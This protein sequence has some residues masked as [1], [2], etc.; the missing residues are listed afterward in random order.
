M[1]SESITVPPHP[2]S[3]ESN[4]LTSRNLCAL[5]S[6]DESEV[7]TFL[8]QR[9]VDNS[10]IAGL[11]R[12]NGLISSHNRG[13]F[14]GFR[15]REGKLEGVALVGRKTI[16]ETHNE[17]ALE[18]FAELSLKSTLSFLLRGE[19]NQAERLLSY[20]A[21][22]GRTPRLICYEKMLVQN[23]PLEGI[24][25]VSQL[26]P[27]TYDCLQSVVDVNALMFFEE[28]GV[29]PLYVDPEG[30]RKRIARRIEQR[31]VWT[32]IEDGRLIFKADVITETPEAV[33]LE[34]I[35][36]DPAE[37]G[38]GVGLRCMTQLARNLLQRSASLCLIVNEENIRARAL[39]K[40]AGYKL[41]SH[42]NTL[43]FSG[44]GE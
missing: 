30:M 37:R 33:F 13:S 4:S 2:L 28:N 27:A 14:Y 29:N 32:W 34:G 11:I 5:T 31:R 26:R 16:I 10:F 19:Q 44:T 39:Y 15:N 17:S 41:H 36:V 12:D 38:K 20:F 24:E 1:L 42:Y 3:L 6:Q 40:K 25:E 35:Y 7:L 23:S 22:T 43:Y 21:K 18:A 8:A 9:P